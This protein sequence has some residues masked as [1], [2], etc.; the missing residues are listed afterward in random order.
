MHLEAGED[1]PAVLPHHPEITSYKGHYSDL[2]LSQ[3]IPLCAKCHFAVHHGLRLCQVCGEHYHQWYGG[4][5]KYCFDKEHPEIV[6]AR[7]EFEQNRKSNEKALKEARN[8]KA[9]EAKRKHPCKFRRVG[10]AC[11]RSVIGAR[12][13]YSSNAAEEKCGDFVAKKG[14]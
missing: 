9:R 12:C 3:C 11:G 4:E 7:E 5:C 8:E 14:R 2:E 1:V 10:G 6:K 13:I